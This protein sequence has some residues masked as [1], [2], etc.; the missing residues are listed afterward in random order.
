MVAPKKAAAGPVPTLEETLT[1]PKGFGLE[2]ATPV[3]RALCRIVEGLPLGE[4]AE[5]PRVIRAVGGP[6]AAALL[7]APVGRPRKVYN[8][9][10]IRGGK[11]LTLAAAATSA[12][13]RV[14]V[15]R[16]GSGEVPR[17]SILATSI[18][19]AQVSFND[20]LVGKI[21]AS[22]VLRSL[23]LE[24]P[25]SDSILLRHPSG[26]PVE[27]KVV[28]GAR[29]GATLVARWSAGMAADEAPR[30]HGAEAVVNFED[31]V[32]AVEGRL[33]P[34]AQIFAFGS[35]W[36]PDG[37]VYDTVT[38]RW[39]KPGL[40][41]V[42][43]RAPAYDLN[44]GW[45][46]PERCEQLRTDNPDAYRTDVE[47][48]FADADAAMFSS[49]EVERAV[50]KGLLELPPSRGRSY[51][52]AMDPATRGNAWTLAIGHHEG[53]R[54]IVDV[55]RQW[56]GSRAEP[57]DPRQV[58]AEVAQVLGAYDLS[59]ADTDQ[60]G[61]DFVAAL[62]DNAGISLHLV[63][64]TSA[65]R[66][67]AYDA[68]RRR[69]STGQ[70]ELPPDPLVRADLIAVRRR[71]TLGGVQIYLPETSDGRHTDYAPALARLAVQNDGGNDAPKEEPTWEE[72][73]IERRQR[74]LRERRQEEES[75]A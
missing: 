55:A 20:H 15:S 44:P 7:S 68:L 51:F 10:G 67:A 57:L 26:R 59:E 35:P 31:S 5:H 52:A 43:L 38:A 13:Q 63:A 16:L 23:V 27:I 72:R 64:W 65:N 66:L 46:T 73:E 37:P 60:L 2:D 1:R 56:K 50:R 14:D 70:V 30:M 4:L 62:A 54:L 48:E 53:T 24:E 42:V 41:L 45:W 8:I 61:Y 74:K 49:V 40:D 29:A 39:G 17:F 25:K 75:W 21:M 33:L 58:L 22:P 9:S 36:A 71:V 18:D 47:A 12:T 3:Q 34:G 6:E 19:I 28:A 32:R 11:S 69:L